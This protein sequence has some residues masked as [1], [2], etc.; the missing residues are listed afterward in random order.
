MQIPEFTTHE[1][2]MFF[3]TDCAGVVHN[4]AYL[5]M[6]ETCRTHLGSAMGMDF[7]T[8]GESSIFPAVVR[9]E[10]DYRI[11]AKLGDKLEVFGRLEQLERV[12][13]W[14]SFVITRQSDDKVLV[15][16]R[17]SLALIEM[18]DDKPARPIRLPQDWRD[19][20]GKALK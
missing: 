16:C 15:Q 9:T 18:Y 10:I 6:I 1:D 3:D 17:Q 7:K 13:F 11:P 12:R 4:I 5:R 20:W 8:M 2:V 19:Q 14:C